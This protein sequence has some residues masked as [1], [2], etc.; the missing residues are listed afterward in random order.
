[1]NFVDQYVRM[2][3]A[4]FDHMRSIIFFSWRRSVVGIKVQNLFPQAGSVP[5]HHG[6]LKLFCTP[7][8][9]SFCVADLVSR[10]LIVHIQTS[11]HSHGERAGAHRGST[12]IPLQRLRQSAVRSCVDF[13]K[14]LPQKRSVRDIDGLRRLSTGFYRPYKTL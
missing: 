7:L 6:M 4:P 13:L 12:N 2:G 8:S 9:L 5:R 10:Q 11:D 3:T 14:D 1:V